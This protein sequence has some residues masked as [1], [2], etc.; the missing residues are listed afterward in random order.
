MLKSFSEVKHR[1][2]LPH[3]LVVIG[4]E[5]WGETQHN[6]QLQKYGIQNEVVFTGHLEYHQLPAIYHQASLL[7]FPS[8]YE[9]FGFPP[10]EAMACGIPVIASRISSI[11]EVVG[12]A[13]ILLDPENAQVWSDTIY[14]VLTNELLQ[15]DLRQKG[16]ERAKQFSWEKTAKLTL[17]VYE[18]AAQKKN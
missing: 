13:G 17:I 10:L 3:K 18:Q 14:M 2:Q 11:P 9:G 12:D 8:L 1:N 5:G 7:V 4:G 16:I 15:L 6:A